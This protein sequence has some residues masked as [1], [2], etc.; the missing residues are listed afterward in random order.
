MKINLKTLLIFLLMNFLNF[1]SLYGEEKYNKIKEP[2]KFNFYSGFFDYT[3][4]VGKSS[5]LGIQHQN[6]S[7][8]KDTFFGTISPVTGFL[9]TADNSTYL[10]TGIKADY[11]IGY[12]NFTP[13]FTP[14][15]YG[16]GGGKDLGHILEFKSELQ[17]SLDLPKNSE[18]GFSWNHISNADIS[19]NN[20]GADN[21]MFNFSKN[22]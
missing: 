3:D 9:M 19:E 15:L 10:Y 17:M 11:K 8:Y 14:G 12:L 13:S 21:Y 20:P 7:L 5:F 22:F 16:K 6:E 2:H 18:F 4:A 1:S